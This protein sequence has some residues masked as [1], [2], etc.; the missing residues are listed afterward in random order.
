MFVEEVEEILHNHPAVADA[1]CVGAPDDRFGAIVC[2]VVAFRPHERL[3]RE[4]LSTYVKQ[5]LAAYKAPRRLVVVDEVP[6]TAQGKPD[7][8]RL[9]ELVSSEVAVGPRRRRRRRRR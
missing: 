4:E 6:R 1:A 7:Y 5:H 3:S 8:P 9:A 2:A